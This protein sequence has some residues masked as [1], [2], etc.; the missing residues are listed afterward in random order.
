[1][2]TTEVRTV[3][4]AAC[5]RN[6][7]RKVRLCAEVIW[8][9]NYGAMYSF[10][11]YRICGASPSFFAKTRYGLAFVADTMYQQRYDGWFPGSDRTVRR[12]DSSIKYGPKDFE[13]DTPSNE[14]DKVY[15]MKEPRTSS[16]WDV[17]R[18][19]ES[20]DVRTA[21]DSA[22]TLSQQLVIVYLLTLSTLCIFL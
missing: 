18:S 14:P 5:R 1:M 17:G 12:Y 16:S 11:C 2:P 8:L 20:F 21:S 7:V 22:D 19:C 13:I 10:T 9:Y 15:D 6:F 3:T 4:V